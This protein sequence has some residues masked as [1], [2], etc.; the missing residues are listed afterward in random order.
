MAAV[1]LL[2]AAGA[3]AALP[4]PS[5][6]AS[7]QQAQAIPAHAPGWLIVKLRASSSPQA[8]AA[9][10]TGSP[11][12]AARHGVALLQPLAVAGG[13]GAAGSGRRLQA[14][15]TL[16]GPGV[17]AITDGASVPAKVRQLEALPGGRQACGSGGLCLVPPACSA[18]WQAPHLPQL[19]CGLFFELPCLQR[20]SGR[21]L[22]TS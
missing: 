7:A 8:A 13:S 17:Y 1:V 11:L 9:G 4:P 19:I 20:W 3:A 14:A 2:L 10:G 21:C 15:S 22:T 16:A 12:T 5:M 18:A 6:G